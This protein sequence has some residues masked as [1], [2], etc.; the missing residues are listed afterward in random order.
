MEEVTMH[1]ANEVLVKAAVTF[2][3]L[4]GFAI[5]VSAAMGSYEI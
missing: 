1:R 4:V 2:V 3:F 5:P